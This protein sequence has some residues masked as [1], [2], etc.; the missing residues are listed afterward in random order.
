MLLQDTVRTQAEIRPEAVA[1]VS[2]KQ[3]MTYGELEDSGDRLARL[4][5]E[6]GCRSG[7]RVGIL[8]PKS[9]PALVGMLGTL[10][11]GCVYVPLDTASPAARL[12]KIV[13]TCEPAVIL[14][15][16]SAAHLLNALAANAPARGAYK[17]GWL[18]SGKPAS[19]ALSPAF[20]WD[21]LASMPSRP[22]E[23]NSAADDAAHIL[24]TS[25]ST[26]IPK[27]VIITH[28]NVVHFLNWAKQYFG[29]QASDRISCHPPLHFDLSTYDIW[30][31]FLAGS[32]LC[33]VPHE[34]SM[35]PHKVADV[36]RRT[37]R[38]HWFS[39][40]S[41]LRYMAQSQLLA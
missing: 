22:V 18:D 35:L 29:A 15:S 37:E 7:D 2:D 32:Q 6:A 30:G 19:D 31:T 40:P 41:L 13:D 27:G 34:F 38:Q 25:G 3:R 26:G 24:F 20:T 39:L 33:L 23:C 5:R 4:L 36:K 9:A 28:S 8:A 11:A 12:S 21:D 16:G 14:A 1:I 17:I 10:K